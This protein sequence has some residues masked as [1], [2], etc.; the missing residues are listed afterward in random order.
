MK[1]FAEVNDMIEFLIWKPSI[2]F[3][4]LF[5]PAFSALAKVVKIKIAV[6]YRRMKAFFE[7]FFGAKLIKE[8]SAY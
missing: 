6:P 8:R 7:K 4:K 2:G 3:K 1:K 5:S